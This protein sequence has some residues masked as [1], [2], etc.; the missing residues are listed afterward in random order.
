MVSLDNVG[1]H[2]PCRLPG[3]AR[4]GGKW[5]WRMGV[6]R[7][8]ASQ[9]RDSKTTGVCMCDSVFDQTAGKGERRWEVRGLGKPG[10]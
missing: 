2:G 1:P 5:S 3:E 9:P 4:S 7:G 8:R 10:S 6:G